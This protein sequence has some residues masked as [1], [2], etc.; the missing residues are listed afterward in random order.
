MARLE[1]HYLAHH[2]F[3]DDIHAGALSAL[4]SAPSVP[5]IL[6]HGRF[7]MICPLDGAF[8]LKE[9]WPTLD[10]RVIQQ[11]G[12]SAGEPTIAEALTQAVEDAKAW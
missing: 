8:A 1:A 6:V 3:F 10:L 11:A 2:C 5:G 9:L 7:D 4:T 12:H